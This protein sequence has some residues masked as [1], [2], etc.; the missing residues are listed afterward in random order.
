MDFT[1][2]QIEFLEK[3]HGAGMSSLRKDGSAHIVRIGVAMV[4]GKLQSS[5]TQERMR[6]KQLRRDP[7]STL[8]VFEQG[9]GF[10][11]VEANVTI[12]EGPDAPQLNLELFRVMQKGM[13]QPPEAGM[14]IWQGKPITEAEFLKAMVDEHRL[15]YQFEPT[16]IYGM[17]L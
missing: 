14:I 12:L 13:P 17:V 2:K 8:F 10:L 6:T 4:N 7:R 1:Q 3:N 5:G 9:Y 16:R 15:V 11:S